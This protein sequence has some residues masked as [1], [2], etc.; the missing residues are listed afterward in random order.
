MLGRVLLRTLPIVTVCRNNPPFPSAF[1]NQ[2]RN[3]TETR[4]L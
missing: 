3:G 4:N 1:N 2:V